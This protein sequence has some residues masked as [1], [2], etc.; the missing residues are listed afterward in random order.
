MVF[1]ILT[2]V[3]ALMFTVPDWKVIVSPAETVSKKSLNDLVDVPAVG[4]MIYAPV[5][6]GVE[7]A[8][9]LVYRSTVIVPVTSF[10]VVLNIP[11]YTVESPPDLY[12]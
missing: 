11:L 10:L 5:E 1:A 4:L 6:S 8:L 12:E 3:V 7:P 9:S 2:L